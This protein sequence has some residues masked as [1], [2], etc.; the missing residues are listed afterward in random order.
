MYSMSTMSI[1]PFW[2]ARCR[3]VSPCSSAKAGSVP[4]LRSDRT[5]STRLYSVLLDF[6][7]YG[8]N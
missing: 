5:T 8:G 6:V 3:G 2:A 7:E 4:A 1:W